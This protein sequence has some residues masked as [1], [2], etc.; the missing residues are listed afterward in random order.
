M[1]YIGAKE[2]LP[3]TSYEEE[4]DKAGAIGCI[5][6]LVIAG[7]VW[8]FSPGDNS[9]SHTNQP[10]VHPP[11]WYVPE[12]Y[13]ISKTF[14][15]RY[16]KSPGSAQFPASSDEIRKSVI[17]FGDGITYRIVSYVDSHNTF[18]ALVR[19]S[20]SCTIKRIGSGSD[21]E[22]ELVDFQFLE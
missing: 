15:K 6:I 22:W 12:A 3:M 14:V 11:E 1:E 18:G 10:T 8:L 4:R 5:V 17:V 2:T 7:L 16:L 9:S 13:S 20:Y 21:R 19:T